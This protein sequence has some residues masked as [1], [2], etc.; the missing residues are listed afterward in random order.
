[1]FLSLAFYTNELVWSR[2]PRVEEFESVKVVI[3]AL[4]TEVSMSNPPNGN[5][6]L[7]IPDFPIDH[8]CVQDLGLSYRKT[9]E[10]S[11]ILYK[12]DV[13]NS[14]LYAWPTGLGDG[15]CTRYFLL[16]DFTYHDG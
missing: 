2:K 14:N 16:F 7:S 6:S 13:R 8:A 10:I 1:M 15:L 9:L 5:I 4:L 12:Q 11:K 3:I